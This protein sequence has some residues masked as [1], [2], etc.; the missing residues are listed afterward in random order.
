L[1]R[2]HRSEIRVT[3]FNPAPADNL[4]GGGRFDG[5]VSDPYPFLYAAPEPETV[6]LESLTRAVPINEQAVRVIPRNFVAGRSLS[7]IRLIRSLRLISLMTAADLAQVGQDEWL[8][9]AGSEAYPQTRSWASWLRVRDPSSQGI[10]WPSSR[11]VGHYCVVLF[12]DRC[13]DILQASN[14]QPIDLDNNAGAAWINR[15]LEPYRYRLLPPRNRGDQGRAGILDE[16]DGNGSKH[17]DESLIPAVAE[18]YVATEV[19]TPE[20]GH[21]EGGFHADSS[22]AYYPRILADVPDG[23]D[24]LEVSSD[25]NM[26]CDLVM[27]RDVAPPLSVGL[28]GNWGTGKSFFMAQMRQ[29]VTVLAEAAEQASLEGQPSGTCA[30]VCQVE[31]NAWHYVDANLWASLASRIFGKLAETD[32][33][34]DALQNL[35]SVRATRH[36]LEEQRAVAQSRLTAIRQELSREASIGLSDLFATSLTWLRGTVAGES[37]GRVGDLLTKAGVQPE[38]ARQFLTLAPQLQAGS[39]LLGY[40]LRRSRWSARFALAGAL[41]LIVAGPPLLTLWLRQFVGVTT[42]WAS[43]LVG[44]VVAGGLLAVPYL[45][46][47]NAFL[48]AATAMINAT[49]E[50]RR[51][52]DAVQAEALRAQLANIEKTISALDARI[53]QLTQAG[54]VQAYALGRIAEDDY[55]RHEGILSIVRRDLEELSRRLAPSSDGTGAAEFPASDMERIILYIDDLDRCPSDRV[56]EVLQAIHLLLAFPLFVVIAGA[57]SRWLLRAVRMHYGD[58]LGARDKSANAAIDDEDWT[59]TPQNYLEKIFQLSLCLRPMTVLGYENLITADVGVSLE[60]KFGILNVSQPGNAIGDRNLPPLCPAQS[61]PETRFCDPARIGSYR[62][63]GQVL[64]VR[65]SSS[66]PFL[67]FVDSRGTICRRDVRRP[68]IDFLDDILTD[69]TPNSVKLTANDHAFIIEKQGQGA[70]SARILNCWTGA[71]TAQIHIITP[72]SGSSRADLLLD[73]NGSS[74][75]ASWR[76]NGEHPCG[77]SLAPVIPKTSVFATDGQTV[78]TLKML[79]ASWHVT[80]DNEGCW[81]TV[82]DPEIPPS[83]LNADT[84]CRFFTDEQE[85]WLAALDTSGRVKVW[86]IG[87][88]PVEYALPGAI[89]ET[90]DIDELCLGPG[91]IMATA[92]D[93]T[94]RVWDLTD[95]ALQSQINVEAR[96]KALAISRDPR[97]MA[98]CTDDGYIRIWLIADRQ[99]RPELAV[100][101]MHLS[102][103]ERS[104]LMAMQPLIRTPRSARRLVNLYRLMRSSLHD[105]SPQQRQPEDLRPAI[106][107][108]A[109]LTGS[110]QEGAEIIE[111]LI[112]NE[113]PDAKT[114]TGMIEICSPSD[115]GHQNRR[116]RQ[117]NNA[118]QEILAATCLAKDANSYAQWAPH[119]ARFSFRTQD[120]S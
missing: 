38:E 85:R 114:A 49:G 70:A 81:W 69:T 30:K 20:L 101:A 71:D 107:L 13:S 39:S 102:E 104:T 25:V 24:L 117:F 26:L 48:K 42:A 7:T 31:F 57:D 59:A 22:V 4:F 51:N 12:G 18:D 15:T 29:R 88:T 119:V 118:V 5:T 83:R 84:N 61:S 86:S 52:V 23:K 105:S 36:S 94:V 68:D 43:A 65:F 109:M 27:A 9:Q 19:R 54:S 74:I 50:T 120:F 111:R 78:G 75:G 112:A 106:L 76:D 97:R 6:L 60:S 35:P 93:R 62:V 40:L 67:I 77:Y 103:V 14:D 32:L 41:G 34:L 89:D 72:R 73:D 56:A 3:N 82:H 79:A 99:Q 37:A 66:R 1:W 92:S 44:C 10:I 16:A 90:T 47:A 100:Q 91:P 63:A 95:R 33:G 55:R 113:I 17:A 2:I 21:S 45:N 46:R 115:P 116:W 87:V 98:I 108:L 96:I 80:A 58:I 64:A 11:N 53:A 8:V 110:P 28:F